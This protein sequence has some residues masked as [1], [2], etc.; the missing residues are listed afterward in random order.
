M[1]ALLWDLEGLIPGDRD[2]LCRLA[3]PPAHCRTLLQ[4]AGGGSAT[5]SSS[6]VIARSMVSI[7]GPN[8]K[9]T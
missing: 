9:R 6:L 8:E 7:D 3:K 2:P 1:Q 5:S 4:T